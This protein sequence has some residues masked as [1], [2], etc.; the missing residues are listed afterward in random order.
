M[1]GTKVT[2]KTLGIVGLGRIG[3]AVARRAHHGFGMRILFHRPAT[4]PEALIGEL[5]AEPRDTLDQLLADCDFVSLHCPSTP[6]TRHLI[7]SERLAQMK[8]GAF[9]IN[10]ARGEVVDE[11]ALAEALASGVIAGAGL[12]V[13]EHEPKVLPELLQ[14]EN[15]VLLPHL[16]SATHETRTAMGMRALDNLTAFFRG[17][18]PPDRVA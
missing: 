15:V 11:R 14:M 3:R 10:T 9:L 13:Y 5:E 17:E 1:L 8:K 6:K 7:D 18:S 4:V 16:G 2:G 12:D